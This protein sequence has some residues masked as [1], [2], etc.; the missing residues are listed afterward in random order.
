[1]F[2]AGAAAASFA[3]I[4]IESAIPLGLVI[5]SSGLVIL[6]VF[7]LLLRGVRKPDSSA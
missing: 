5:A 2:M 4:T 3:A 1:M 7:P 6:L